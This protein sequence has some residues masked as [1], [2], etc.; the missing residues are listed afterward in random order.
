[1]AVAVVLAADT[2]FDG[3]KDSKKVAQRRRETLFVEITAKAIAIGVSVITHEVVDRINILRAS[4]A[5][6][7]DA[8]AQI[9]GSY[10]LALVDGW[11]I[12]GILT[13]QHGV[14]GGDGKSASIAAASI[15]AKVTRDRLMKE[16]S[17][18]YPAYG[19]EKHKGYGTSQHRRALLE[20]GPCLIHRK[21]YAPVKEALALWQAKK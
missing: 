5:G 17:V 11:A 15:I 18:Q 6:M 10:Q 2:R 4:Y 9:S 12:P 16:F 19:F 20:H 13:A 3:L 8:L 1:V 7:S 14:V 21:S